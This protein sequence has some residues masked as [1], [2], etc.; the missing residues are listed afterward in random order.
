MFG[1]DQMRE[2]TVY[3]LYVFFGLNFFSGLPEVLFELVD[4]GLEGLSAR[5]YRFLF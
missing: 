2:P 1:L 5:F 4:P 3:A